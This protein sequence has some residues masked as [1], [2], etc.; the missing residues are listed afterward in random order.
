MMNSELSLATL[1]LQVEQLLALCQDL[2]AEK[3]ALQAQI[4]Q[5]NAE[6]TALLEKNRAAY[7]KVEHMIIRLKALE[8]DHD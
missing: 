2:A 4:Q 5:L 1:K 7:A 8:L 3:Q 6:K